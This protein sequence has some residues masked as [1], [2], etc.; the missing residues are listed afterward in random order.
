[1]ANKYLVIWKALIRNG[2]CELAA[3]KAFHPRIIKAVIN[4]KY[5]DL[6]YKMRLETVEHKKA[7]IA[8]NVEGNKITFALHFR[9]LYNL[10][11]LNG[12]S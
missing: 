4:V 7:F 12:E 5:R 2:V 8:Y 6:G 1:M 10:D 3:H 11:S 9:D